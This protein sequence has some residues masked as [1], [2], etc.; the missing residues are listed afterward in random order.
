[1]PSTGDAGKIKTQTLPSW[2]LQHE[3]PSHKLTKWNRGAK[4][5]FSNSR[6]V[7]VSNFQI[8]PPWH[9]LFPHHLR[10]LDFFL[11]AGVTLAMHP[12]RLDSLCLKPFHCYPTPPPQHLVVPFHRC[13]DIS[14]K[15]CLCTRGAIR[16]RTFDSEAPGRRI[17][18]NSGR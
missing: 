18:R 10:P 17:L 7:C 12:G 5:S 16:F 8:L 4:C 6:S 9:L 15:V 3:P 11:P 1:M 13:E 14:A 2:S